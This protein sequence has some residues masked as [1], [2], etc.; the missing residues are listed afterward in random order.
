MKL[1]RGRWRSEREWESDRSESDPKNEVRRRRTW[2]VV[3]SS[4][5]LTKEKEK[6][7]GSTACN[8]TDNPILI[9]GSDFLNLTLPFLH[10]YFFCPFFFCITVLYLSITFHLRALTIPSS[11]IGTRWISKFWTYSR[12][13]FF[14]FAI[15]VFIFYYEKT[16]LLSKV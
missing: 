12:F 15:A 4:L 10:F 14:L 3:D 8:Q 6:W 1:T 7:K 11:S 9:T 16:I 13:V 5:S 2:C